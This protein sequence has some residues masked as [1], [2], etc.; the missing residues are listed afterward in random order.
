[1]TIIYTEERITCMYRLDKQDNQKLKDR[2]QELKQSKIYADD[3]EQ[4]LLQVAC[5]ELLEENE[6][7]PIKIDEHS[8]GV[9]ITSID[10]DW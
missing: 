10:T 2:V 8:D 1:M 3:D 6:I 4:M 5:D 7:A 9:E